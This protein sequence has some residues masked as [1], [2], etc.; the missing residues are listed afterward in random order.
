M[1]TADIDLANVA[2][3]PIGQTCATE[4][5]GVFDGQN[6][7]IKNMTIVNTDESANCASGLF[8]WIE[9]HDNNNPVTVKNVK[10]DNANVTGN[11]NVAVVA[12]Y[13]Y[14]TI[15]NCEVKNS[16]VIG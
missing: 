3:S 14:G 16:T 11:H 8:G 15:E 13:I 2:W 6:H 5:K 7:T 1:L 9:S 12:G 4:F 10:F